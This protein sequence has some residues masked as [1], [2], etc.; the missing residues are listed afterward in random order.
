MIRRT[1]RGSPIK[2]V[3]SIKAHDPAKCERFAE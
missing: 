3:R 2:I 1:V